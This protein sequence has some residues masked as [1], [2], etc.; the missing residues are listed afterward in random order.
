MANDVTQ[1][2]SGLLEYL[3]EIYSEDSFLGQYL[4]AFEKILLRNPDK[5]GESGLEQKIENIASYF[6][7]LQESELLG[8]TPLEFLQ[9]L[10]GWVALSLRADLTESLQRKFIRNAVRLYQLRG[11]KK[12]L[13]EIV[14]LYAV[15]ATI[16]EP[17]F[18][19]QVETPGRSRVE[20]ETVIEGGVPFVFH[21]LVN[22]PTTDAAE[23]EKQYDVV[24]AILNMEKPSH[25]QFVLDYKTPIMQIEDHSRVEEDTLL[26]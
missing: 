25:T 8:E 16:T 15:S 11:T 19:F 2:S 13:E 23:I 12:G 9:W 20:D 26:G 4:A 18:P 21:V 5:T 10:S 6:N 17:G 22:I 24:T 1:T 14:S 3:P 7:P